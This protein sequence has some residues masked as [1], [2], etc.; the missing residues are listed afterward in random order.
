MLRLCLVSTGL[1]PVW[2][3]RRVPYERLEIGLTN[4]QVGALAEALVD[5][6]QNEKV[7]GLKDLLLNFD[8][9]E[10]SYDD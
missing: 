6:L 4:K 3:I 5:Y 1:H 9:G 10:I 7:R 8:S 2:S